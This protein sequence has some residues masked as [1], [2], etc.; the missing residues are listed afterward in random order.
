MCISAVSYPNFSKIAISPCCIRTNTHVRVLASQTFQTG[1]SIP[2][3]NASNAEIWHIICL[4]NQPYK[5]LS[6]ILAKTVP[7]A[8]HIYMLACCV[9]VFKVQTRVSFARKRVPDNMIFILESKAM[10]SWETLD[11]TYHSE[12]GMIGS[13]LIEISSSNLLL[14][15]WST[16]LWEA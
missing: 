11:S 6:S 5:M 2:N 4:E 7:Q 16:S 3:P 14:Y 9:L 15:L 8:N 1:Q 10:V 13:D 12:E